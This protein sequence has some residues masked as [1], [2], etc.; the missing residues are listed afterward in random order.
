LTIALVAPPKHSVPSFH[1]DKDGYRVRAFNGENMRE[2]R[3]I[4]ERHLGR[5]LLKQETV[6]HKN[7][8]KDDNRLE[9]LELWTGTQPPGQRVEDK[10]KWAKEIL[11]LYKV[12]R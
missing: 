8:I 5:K 10:I 12:G 11:A 4:M 1:F 2:H 3:W 6:H 7:G 9:N